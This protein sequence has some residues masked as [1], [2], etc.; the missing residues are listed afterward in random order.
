MPF[1]VG[2]AWVGEYTC[3]QGVTSLWLRV[4]RVGG[5]VVDAVFQFDWGT[6]RG[7]FAMHGTYDG[8]SRRMKFVPDEW[9]EQPAGW[10]MVGMDGAV[11]AAG[12]Y[13]GSITNAAC[14]AFEV[15]REQ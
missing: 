13:R 8:S 6:T 10:V 4:T 12:N 1:H 11:D 5:H 2:D 14:G 7:S 9:I 3:A 15:S